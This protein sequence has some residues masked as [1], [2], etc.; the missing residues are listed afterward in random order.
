MMLLLKYIQGQRKGKEAHRIEREAMRDP[1][2]AEALEGFDAV[3]GLH[4]ERVTSIRKRLSS[5][6]RRTYLRTGR[7]AAAASLLLCILA[8]GYFLLNRPSSDRLVAQS[9]SPAETAAEERT[10]PDPS[11]DTGNEYRQRETAPA[12]EQKEPSPPPPPV[13]KELT[14]VEEAHAPNENETE[15]VSEREEIMHLTAK[16]D[17]PAYEAASLPETGAVRKEM[18]VTEKKAAMNHVSEEPVEIKT[19][20]PAPEPQTGMKAYREYLAK[21]LIRPSEGACAGVKGTVE[22]QFRI[23]TRGK[24]YDF[25]VKRSL[26]AEADREA[27]RLIGQGSRWTGDLSQPVIVEVRF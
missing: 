25:T 9:E 20:L 1:F 18:P 5:R 16:E 8:G 4:T 6:T 13:A 24:P 3:D 21:E 22:I 23:D 15:A 10:F 11:R 12:E 26:C 7:L 2:L 14:V 17:T 27:I 19:P